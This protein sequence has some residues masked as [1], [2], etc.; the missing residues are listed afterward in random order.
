M[1]HLM[2]AA[3]AL[4]PWSAPSQ[5]QE[6]AVAA[7]TQPMPEH[8][9]RIDLVRPDAP[10][11]APFGDHAVGVRT[12]SLTDEARIDIVNATEEGTPPTY[13]RTLTV[14]VCYPPA[15]GPDPGCTYE[16]LLR[17]GRA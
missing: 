17:G 10:E 14:D 12:L 8:Q 6:T 5:A 9:N 13:D 16:A 1:K 15:R 4:L 2:V 7:A 3:V 11:L